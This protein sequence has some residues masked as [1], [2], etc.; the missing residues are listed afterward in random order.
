AEETLPAKLDLIMERMNLR[1]R[2]KGETVAIKVHTG[3]NIGYSTVHPV[4]MRKVVKAVIEGGGKPFIT[5]TDW[6]VHDAQDR[7]YTA[8]VL[9]CPIFPAAGLNDR[10]HYKHHHP[11]K[12]IEDWEVAGM[13]QDASFLINFAHVKGHPSCSFG[14]A[15]KNLALGC[16]TGK[17][18]GKMHDTMHYDPYW[19]GEK[20]TDRQ[21][22]EA[23]LASCPQEA[24][25]ED[26]HHPGEIH[27]HFEQCNQCG[28][29]L[30]VAPEGSLKIQAANFHTFM[31]ACAISTSKTLST[32]EPGK[33][34]HLA[35]ATQ[36]TAV[37]DCFGFTG[38][39]ILPDAGIFGSDDIMAL[40]NAVLDMTARTPLIE[41]NVPLSMEVVTH[42]GHPFSWI[43]GQLK[44]PYKILDFGE[45]YGLGSREYELVDVYPVERVERAGMQYIPAN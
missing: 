37:C 38:M 3:G 42:E 16:M 45:K 35:L 27:M 24:L 9:G 31:E 41:E 40:E 28:R 10:Y 12:G 21:T 14:S 44:D 33:A 43:H 18:R 1:E 29:C 4:F 20:C 7:G 30:K 34:V 2:V 17:V 13:V 22:F 6:D 25:V 39:A 15:V 11:Y 36:M 5:D 32:F 23:I 26:K 19:F 8:E